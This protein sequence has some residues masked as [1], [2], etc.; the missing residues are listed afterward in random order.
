MAFKQLTKGK[1]RN[2]GIKHGK[3]SLLRKAPRVKSRGGR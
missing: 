2:S 1:T 3:K